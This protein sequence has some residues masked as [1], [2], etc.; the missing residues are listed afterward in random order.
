MNSLRLSVDLVVLY[1]CGRRSFRSSDSRC[2]NGERDRTEGNRQSSAVHQE[3]CD[4]WRWRATNG[5]STNLFHMVATPTHHHVVNFNTAVKNK[6]HIYR[7]GRLRA[8]F[9]KAVL[10]DALTSRE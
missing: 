3:V 10:F 2:V 5:I 4:C 7:N 9:A 6:R 1:S 8:S